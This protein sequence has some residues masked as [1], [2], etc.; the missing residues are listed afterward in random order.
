MEALLRMIVF[1]C[2]VTCPSLSPGSREQSLPNY[3]KTQSLLARGLELL[4]AH[5]PF[6]LFSKGD[7]LSPKLGLF[8]LTEK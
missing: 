7:H 5:S 6:P 3:D 2:K 1:V 8:R 4:T